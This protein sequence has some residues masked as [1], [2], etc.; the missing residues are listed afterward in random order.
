[1]AKKYYSQDIPDTLAEFG[2]DAN[3]GI[4]S[5]EAKKRLDQYGPTLWPARRNVQCLPA[6]WTSSRT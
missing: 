2:S 1:V 3:H 4:S 6:S 5:A